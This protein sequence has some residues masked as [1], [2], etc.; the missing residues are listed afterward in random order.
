MILRDIPQ[1][2]KIRLL[3]ARDEEGSEFIKET[4]TFHRLDG[5]YS[6]CTADTDGTVI[7]LSGS[8]PVKLVEEGLYEVDELELS[9][10]KDQ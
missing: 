10:E 6:Y 9:R 1:E 7:H 3:L 4:V 5:M 8:M 2:S